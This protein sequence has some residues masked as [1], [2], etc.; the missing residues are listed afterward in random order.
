MRRAAW[1][2]FVFGIRGFFMQPTIPDY[3]MLIFY[4]FFINLQINSIL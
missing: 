3:F 1:E 2:Q 4:D